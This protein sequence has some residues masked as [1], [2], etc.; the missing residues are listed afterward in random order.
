MP[1]RPHTKAAIM[2]LHHLLAVISPADFYVELLAP[3]HDT[4]VSPRIDAVR[5]VKGNCTRELLQHADFQA[6][7]PVS[8][9]PFNRCAHSKAIANAD[10]DQNQCPAIPY[11]I[12]YAI[13][14][15]NDT[16]ALCRCNRVSLLG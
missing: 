12:A 9:P 3:D 16:F 4:V 5:Q 14:I 2:G 11:T 7:P 10:A 8:S 6:V 15:G 13:R 1:P